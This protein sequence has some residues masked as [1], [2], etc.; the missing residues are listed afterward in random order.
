MAILVGC[1]DDDEDPEVGTSPPDMMRF[2]NPDGTLPE[3]MGVDGSP[4]PGAGDAA[5]A[6]DAAPDAEVIE[7]E[8]PFEG[9]S[10]VEVVEFVSGD[11]P[12]FHRKLGQ[13][14]D[15]RLYYDLRQVTRDNLYAPNAE[16]FI[17]TF[18]PDGLDP[19]SQQW[20]VTIDG[21]VDSEVSFEVSE[22]EPWEQGGYVLECS[23]NGDFSQFGLL[24]ACTFEGVPMTE[25]LERVN[26]LPEAVG[27]LVNGFDHHE[28]PSQGG[29]STPGAA[30]V[31]TFAQLEET[32]AFLATTMNGESLPPD[33]GY[34]VRLVVPGWYGCSNI[35]WVDRI[36]LIDTNELPTSQMREFDTR[37]H[38]PRPTPRLAR[39]FLPASMDQAAMP[40]RIEHWI[41]NGERRYRI[42]GVMWGG[43]EVTDALQIQFNNEGWEDVELCPPHAANQP[44][45][46]WEHTWTPRNPGVYNISCRINDPNVI[47]KRL[48][49]GFYDRSVRLA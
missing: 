18:Y 7:C 20:S 48:D 44:W 4:D 6:E 21:L 8:S 47:T 31:F 19:D 36:T 30:W 42:V 27:V 13:G 37:T 3:D 11:N 33:H 26:I 32:R 25:I 2:T 9:G 12:P 17:R 14:W 41:V 35:K 24:S 10:L 1:N 29:H 23:G 38:Q 22:L 43:Y 49:F 46:V 39:D 34:P 40:T 28:M 16:F 15:G 5:L 45:T